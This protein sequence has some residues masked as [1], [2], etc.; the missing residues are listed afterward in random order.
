ME[1]PKGV[2]SVRN[3]GKEFRDFLTKTNMLALALG[4]V[5]GGAV[6]KV[7]DACVAD[8]LMPVISVVDTQGDWRGWVLPGPIKLKFGHLLGAV[9]D[10]AIIGGVV[11]VATKAFLKSAPPAPTKTCPACKE[12]I[13]PEATRCKFCTSEQ[14]KV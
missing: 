2:D 10:F 5:I 3:L 6:G 14:P 12:G 8:L 9:L 4:V 13:H 11:F 7:V 1:L